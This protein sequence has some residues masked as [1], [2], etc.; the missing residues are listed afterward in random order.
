[1]TLPNPEIGPV[2]VPD[3]AVD[4]G[5]G[6]VVVTGGGVELDDPPQDPKANPAA[7]IKKVVM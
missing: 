2:T 3:V 1:M 4:T 7:P 6:G 5:G